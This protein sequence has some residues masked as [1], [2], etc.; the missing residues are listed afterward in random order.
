MGLRGG[1]KLAQSMSRLCILEGGDDPN[2]VH[3]SCAE[4][5]NTQSQNVVNHFYNVC[6]AMFYMVCRKQSG[7]LPLRRRTP[8]AERRSPRLLFCVETERWFGKSDSAILG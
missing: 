6:F 2:Q 7:T 8:N 3:R 5:A 1:R 4:I